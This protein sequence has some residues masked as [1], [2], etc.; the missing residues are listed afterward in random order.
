MSVDQHTAMFRPSV[1]HDS[2]PA[3]GTDF[4]VWLVAD[5][6]RAKELFE[7]AFAEID[8]IDASLSSYRATSEISRINRRATVERESLP[9][10]QAMV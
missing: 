7:I 4:D 3:M 2:R 5:S 10:R 1:F 6:S 9:S 8:R